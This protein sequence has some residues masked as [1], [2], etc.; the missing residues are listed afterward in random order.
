MPTEK[1]LALAR[2][3]LAG[4]ASGRT[5][6]RLAALLKRVRSEER[7]LLERELD[8]LDRAL[9][10]I[11][12]NGGDCPLSRPPLPDLCPRTTRA[13]QAVARAALARVRARLPR[14]A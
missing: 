9:H 14:G 7:K 13:D 11:A 5:E 1:D 10:T 4:A 2:R 12:R 8:R 3:W 6:T